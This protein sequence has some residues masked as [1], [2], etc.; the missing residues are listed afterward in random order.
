LEEPMKT[1]ALKSWIITP[2]KNAHTHAHTHTHTHT[3]THKYHP[4]FHLR[5]FRRLVPSEWRIPVPLFSWSLL[6]EGLGG[7]RQ[8]LP[9]LHYWGKGRE[10]MK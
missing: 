7:L 1:F 6:S 9:V 5:G 10:G 4:S 2:S 3:H 8:N